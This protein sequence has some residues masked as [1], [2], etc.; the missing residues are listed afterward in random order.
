MPVVARGWIGDDERAER[1][2]DAAGT[3]QARLIAQ[4]LACAA[5]R[6]RANRPLHI[7]GGLEG[8][9]LKRANAGHRSEGSFRVDGHRLAAA[10]RFFHI[11]G[12]AHASLRDRCGR[13]RAGRSGG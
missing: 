8:A 4:N 9:E 1:H 11:F 3:R 5:H 7:H 2:R 13:R 6:D 10:E 12:L